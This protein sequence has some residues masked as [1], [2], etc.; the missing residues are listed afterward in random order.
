MPNTKRGDY[1][2]QL[3][4]AVGNVE[5]CLDKV[6]QLGTQFTE[7]NKYYSDNNLELPELNQA[8]ITGLE[9]ATEYCDNLIAV[10]QKLHEII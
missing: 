9:L 3:E 7:S 10:L 8:I 2:Q 4:R 1:R 6:A 5:W